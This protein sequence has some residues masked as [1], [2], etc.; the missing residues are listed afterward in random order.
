MIR[1]DSY[2]GTGVAHDEPIRSMLHRHHCVFPISGAV[3]D[4]RTNARNFEV[5]YLSMPFEANR[6]RSMGNRHLAHSSERPVPAPQERGKVAKDF[7]DAI[8]H[9]RN[10][11]NNLIDPD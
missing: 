9:F 8:V 11:A 10:T 6:Q 2:A 7:S 5:A 1:F 3:N 4:G